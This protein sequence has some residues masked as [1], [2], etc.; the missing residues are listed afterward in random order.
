M[1]LNWLVAGIGDISTKRVI[2]AIQSEPRSV[3][4]AVLTRDPAK[5]AAY[6]EARV[7]TSLSEALANPEIGAA[8]EQRSSPAAPRPTT[9]KPGGFPARPP[10]N[11]NRGASG[12]GSLGGGGL[13]S[14][15]DAFDTSLKKK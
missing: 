8:K 10:F 11:P 12:G 9:G 4:A 1:V 15:A 3:L 5:A 6:P 7:Y 2:P 13:G 14:L